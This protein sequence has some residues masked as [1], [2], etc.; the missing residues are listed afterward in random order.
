MTTE[1]PLIALLGTG[2]MGSPM[3]LRLHQQGHRLIVWNRSRT[4]LAP[5]AAAGLQVAET[6]AEAVHQADVVLLMLADEAAIEAVFAQIPTASW[7]GRQVLQM[8]TISP[9]QTRQLSRRLRAHGAEML[10]C[11]VL[12][13]LPQAGDGSLILI[14]AGDDSVQQACQ[15]ILD[16]LGQK[17]HRLGTEPGRAAAAKLALNQL[18][19][20]LIAMFGLSLHYVQRQEIAPEA[21]ME[22]LRESALYAPTYDKKLERLLSADFS[23]PNFPIRH[24]LK[25][26]GLFRD[27]AAPLG[28][29]T[30]MLDALKGL[31]QKCADAG[32]EDADYSAVGQA[33][34]S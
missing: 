10:A 4:K 7:Q 8:G 25:D 12:G 29:D 19:P 14:S 20:S 9:E 5:L 3:A 30:R 28:L 33:V 32:L 13:S 2:L 34:A 11:P 16:S 24:M 21:F 1:L 26:I 6:P 22:I 23:Q 15:P 17:Q 18:I 31:L 27:T